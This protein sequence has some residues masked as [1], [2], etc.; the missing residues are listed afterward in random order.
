MAPISSQQTFSHSRHQSFKKASSKAASFR[1]TPRRTAPSTRQPLELANRSPVSLGSSEDDATGWS[2]APGVDTASFGTPR[3]AASCSIDDLDGCGLADLEMMY[4]DALWDYYNPDESRDENA[5]GRLSDEMYDQL[6]D[7]LS[8]QG[9]GFPTLRRNEIAFVKAA[10]S[11]SRGAPVVSDEEYEEL[12][13][14]VRSDGKRKDVTAL[15]LYVKG[16]ELLDQ[17]QYKEMKEE[18]EKLGIEVKASNISCTLTRVSDELFNDVGRVLWMYAGLSLFPTGAAALIPIAAHVA[19]YSLPLDGMLPIGSILFTLAVGAIGGNRLLYYTGLNDATIVTGQCPCCET[20]FT[21][22]WAGGDGAGKGLA[23][24]GFFGG[25]EKDVVSTT[26]EHR[27]AECATITIL[28][29]E[30][31]KIKLKAIDDDPELQRGIGFVDR[32]FRSG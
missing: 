6:R 31:M 5:F 8:W 24:D 29:K 14:R 1:R 25:D 7:E 12:K 13:Q 16:Q 32:A 21:H 18:M 27:C 30:T 9:S 10:I 11:F 19:G 22:L 3:P 17:Q 26:V 23:W 2:V 28:D 4:V 20:E 15:L